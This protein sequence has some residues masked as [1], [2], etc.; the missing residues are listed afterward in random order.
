[1]LFNVIADVLWSY[2]TE[3][4]GGKW[5]KFHL[6]V[7]AFPFFGILGFITLISTGKALVNLFGVLR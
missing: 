5:Y 1:M 3:F 7:T 6:A 2:F 4:Y